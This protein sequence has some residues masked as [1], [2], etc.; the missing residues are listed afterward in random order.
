MRQEVCSFMRDYMAQNGTSVVLYNFIT[1]EMDC[2]LVCKEHE[3]FV[4]LLKQGFSEGLCSTNLISNDSLE[5]IKEFEQKMNSR[6]SSDSCYVSVRNDVTKPFQWMNLT[7]KLLGE[8]EEDIAIVILKNV[9]NEVNEKLLDSLYDKEIM[10]G[11]AHG[12][13][14]FIVN[15]D[16]GVILS[17]YGKL[18]IKTKNFKEQ[19][20]YIASM[21][22]E[23]SQKVRA[24]LGKDNL[25][26]LIEKNSTFELLDVLIKDIDNKPKWFKVTGMCVK[27]PISGKNVIQITFF[28]ID[29]NYREAES[30]KYTATH[31]DLTDLLNKHTFK[32]RAIEKLDKLNNSFWKALI[33]IDIDDFKKINDVLG[34]VIGDRVLRGVALGIKKSFRKNDVIGR[35]GGDEFMVLFSVPTLYDLYSRLELLNENIKQS[36]QI[37]NV[38]VSMGVALFDDNDYN[39]GKLYYLS[40]KAMYQA[41]RMGKNR[42]YVVDQYANSFLNDIMLRMNNKS[43]AEI[44]KLKINNYIC[45]HIS[46]GKIFVDYITHQLANYVFDGKDILTLEN[47]SEF[48]TKSDFMKIKNLILNSSK[49][50]KILEDSIKIKGETYK[51]FASSSD[52]GTIVGLKNINDD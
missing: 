21:C 16:D 24:T 29:V 52:F 10:S 23:M 40:D 33:F 2:E 44:M 39:F 6:I 22:D 50:T 7:Y 9:H 37:E 45:C 31:D 42:F 47:I 25:L 27:H 43:I 28:D 12:D 4:K 26:K 20:D 3:N 19:V 35:V 13:S 46:E 1:R 14:Y 51:V 34:H 48:L 18:A 5:T 30:I 11:V 32:D 36:A 17:S 49:Q 15:I 8:N 38:S 41:K